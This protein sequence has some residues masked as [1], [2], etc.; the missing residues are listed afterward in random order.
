MITT[1]LDLLGAMLIILAVCLAVA[2]LVPGP[3]GTPCAIF[4]G[5]LLV[6]LF[7]IILARR[8]R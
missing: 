2:I 6:T 7:S 8:A 4:T 5:G 1:L 3:W